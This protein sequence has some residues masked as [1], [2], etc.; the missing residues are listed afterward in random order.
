MAHRLSAR[1]RRWCDDLPAVTAQIDC[2]GGQHR[3]TWRRGKLVLEDHDLL[4][5]RSLLAL[6]SDAPP[7]VEVLHAWRRVR[8]AT[9]L[10]TCLF[11]EGTMPPA[12]LAVWRAFYE[13]ETDRLERAI[14]PVGGVAQAPH[15]G[16]AALRARN[17]RM[18]DTTLIEALSPGLRTALALSIIVGIARHWHDDEYRFR[19]GHRVESALATIAN[20]LLEESARRWRCNVR[21]HA[22]FTIDTQALAPWE[23]PRCA[24][25][26][27]TGRAVASLSLPVSWLLDVWA[28]DAQDEAAVDERDAARR[29]RDDTTLHVVAVRWARDAR[30]GSQMVAAPALLRRGADGGWSLRWTADEPRSP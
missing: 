14:F 2:G 1:P 30:H 21:P 15:A 24:G 3:I 27:G 6:G 17:L 9:M 4:A 10:R 22:I 8:D 7:C 23:R 11:R 26:V 19:H 16:R 29:P 20:R 13:A 25:S 28:R 18:W 12:E 5:E